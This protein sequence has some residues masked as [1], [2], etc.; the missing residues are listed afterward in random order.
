MAMVMISIMRS[1]WVCTTTNRSSLL[2]SDVTYEF[3]GGTGIR[4]RPRSISSPLGAKDPGTIA[5]AIN[6]LCPCSAQMLV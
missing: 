6:C 5:N 4:P 2:D 3:E 1:S